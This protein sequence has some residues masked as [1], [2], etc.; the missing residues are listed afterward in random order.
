MKFSSLFQACFYFCMVITVVTLFINIVG[1][2]DVFG[3]SNYETGVNIGEDPDNVFQDVSGLSNGYEW[4]WLAAVGGGLGASILIGIAT[5][6]TIPIGVFLFGTVFWTSYTRLMSIT[7]NYIPNDF[8]LGI[9]VALMFL[10]A[11]A[12]I[13]LLSGGG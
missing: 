8:M 5:S 12:V 3:E 4:F 7:G 11:G 9:T 1:A 6:S 10:F 2:M 13:G